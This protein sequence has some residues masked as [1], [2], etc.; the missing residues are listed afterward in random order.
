[1]YVIYCY[2]QLFEGNDNGWLAVRNIRNDATN[3]FAT[4]YIVHYVHVSIIRLFVFIYLVYS[5]CML[6]LYITD[7][8]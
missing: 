7:N 8:S 3:N 1:M 2:L 5:I 4:I 6:Y